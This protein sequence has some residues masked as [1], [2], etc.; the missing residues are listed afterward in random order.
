MG[1]C[2]DFENLFKKLKIWGKMKKFILLFLSTVFIYS[3]CFASPVLVEPPKGTTM[4]SIN[5]DLTWT[6]DNAVYYYMDISTDQYFTGPILYFNHIV[7][8][9]VFVV[10]EGLLQP[11]TTYYWKVT[12]YYLN[13]MSSTSD[14]FNFRTIGTSSEEIGHLT[15]V[16]TGLVTNSNLPLNKVTF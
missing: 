11:N 12:S 13:N 5:P 14:I 9:T 2:V 4:V 1:G 3:N 16:V 15:D 8:D 7:T 6:N 10:P